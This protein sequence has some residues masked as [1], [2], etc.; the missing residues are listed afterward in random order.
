MKF[1]VHAGLW[2]KA[3]QD[4][5]LPILDIAADLGFDGVELSLLGIGMDRASGIGKA[6]P[7]AGW[8]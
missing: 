7:H 6:A 8:T 1:G 3:W 4:D 5:P 2:M